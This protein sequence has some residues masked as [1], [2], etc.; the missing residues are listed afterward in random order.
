M[1]GFGTFELIAILAIFVLFVGVPV[2]GVVLFFFLS[3]RNK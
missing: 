3:K 1:A 2:G